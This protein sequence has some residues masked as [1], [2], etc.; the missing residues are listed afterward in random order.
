MKVIAT[1][2]LALEPNDKP[3]CVATAAGAEWREAK[4]IGRVS[5]ESCT[6]Q[7]EVSTFPLTPGPLNMAIKLLDDI[8]PLGNAQLLD[9]GDLLLVNKT[10]FAGL[11][12]TLITF[13]F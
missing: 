2:T 7:F 6:I 11:H 4:A 8:Y 10:V 12:P 1:S 9:F 13:T 5:T 3:I